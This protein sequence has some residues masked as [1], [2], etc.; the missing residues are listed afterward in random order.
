MDV[1]NNSD[2][3][4]LAYGWVNYRN[5]NLIQVDQIVEIIDNNSEE[6]DNDEN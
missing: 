2:S 1:L 4:W 5:T 3:G 6:E